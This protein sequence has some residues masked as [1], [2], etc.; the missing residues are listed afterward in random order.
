MTNDLIFSDS[1]ADSQSYLVWY[2]KRRIKR[3][4]NF[5]ALIIGGTGSGKSFS[6]MGLAEKLDTN[7]NIDRVVFNSNDFIT[8]LQ[9][10]TLK[11]GAV[12]IYDEV[13]TGM[14]HMEFWTKASIWM[15]YILQTF[16]KDSIVVLFTTPNAK[17]L[18]VNARRLLH[19]YFQTSGID[20][21]KEQVKIKPYLIQTSRQGKEYAK[22]PRIIKN[23]EPCRLSLVKVGMPTTKL[24]KAYEE[25]ANVYKDKIKEDGLIVLRQGLLKGNANGLDNPLN[26]NIP[27][28]RLTERQKQTYDLMMTGMSQ[29]QV[30]EQLGV[31][32]GNISTYVKAIRKKGYIC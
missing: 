6:A 3:N 24:L 28:K 15:N 10:G 1:M 21:T 27:I 29:K 32:Q 16:R 26:P 7:F 19:A 20:Y 2:I 30:G 23:G 17:F 18:N 31:H 8:L 5:M 11:K 9:S 12:I 22:F 13:G 4:Q 14:G 25:K